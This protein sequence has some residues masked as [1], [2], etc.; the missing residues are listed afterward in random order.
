MG[1][2]IPCS[3]PGSDVAEVGHV[4]G[5]ERACRGMV[6]TASGGAYPVHYRLYVQGG[7]AMVDIADVPP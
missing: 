4:D 7:A 6:T 2:G 5:V 1:S 3:P